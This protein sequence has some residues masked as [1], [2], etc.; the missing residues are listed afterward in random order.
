MSDKGCLKSTLEEPSHVSYAIKICCE[1][2]HGFH[3]Q[4]SQENFQV[5]LIQTQ[6]SKQIVPN[7]SENDYFKL[8]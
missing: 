1:Y 5:H 2:S 7:N 6:N 4:Q 8:N 3:L